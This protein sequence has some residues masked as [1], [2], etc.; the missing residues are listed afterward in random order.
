MLEAAILL[1]HKDDV[2]HHVCSL[3]DKGRGD[4]LSGVHGDR[5]GSGS[6]ACPT[7]AAKIGAAAGSGSQTNHGSISEVRTARAP[8]VDARWIAGHTPLTTSGERY[9]QRET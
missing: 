8:A 6:G 2:I 1:R 3:R 9:S 5:A 7:P 4:R